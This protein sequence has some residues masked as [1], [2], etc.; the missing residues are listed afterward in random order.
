[1]DALYSKPPQSPS[2]SSIPTLYFDHPLPPIEVELGGYLANLKDWTK[3]DED[4]FGELSIQIILQLGYGKNTPQVSIARK[5]AG[6][7]MAI[8]GRGTDVAV[9]W[10]VAFRDEDS[11]RNFERV[12]W[13]A[14]GSHPC[15]DTTS[16]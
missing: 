3:A 13:R 1:M 7:R 4:T 8:L 16:C 10:I 9:V 14:A 6:D 15:L 5:W 11:A 2:R 12:I